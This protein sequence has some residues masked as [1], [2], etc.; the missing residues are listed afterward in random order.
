MQSVDGFTSSGELP[1]AFVTAVD[2][3]QENLVLLPIGRGLGGGPSQGAPGVPDGLELYIPVGALP[4]YSVVLFS[5]DPMNSPLHVSPAIIQEANRKAA[6]A[7]DQYAVPVALREVHAYDL[8][9]QRLAAP[10]RSMTFTVGYGDPAARLN[11]PVRT[12]SLSLW[13]LDEAHRRWV[14]L[15]D[16]RVRPESRTV[17]S[18]VSRFSA[19]A[20]MGAPFGN[21]SDA[22]IFPNPWRPNGPAAGDEAGRSGSHAGGMTFSQLPSECRIR[23]YTLSGDLVRE[24]KHSDLSGTLAQ[25]RW[26]GKNSRGDVVASGVY[27]WR[28]ESAEDAKNGKL[29][30]IR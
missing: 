29:M 8:R 27:V 19:F 4:E 17:T 15:P 10:L 22:H 28:V 26:D 25:E 14:R 7:L 11:G 9:G 16:S 23:I 21:A 6:A 20:L 2:P 1:A 18:P 30:I 13:A 24:L 12:G 3:G 5:R